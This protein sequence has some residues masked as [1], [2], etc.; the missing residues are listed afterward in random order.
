MSE[1][2]TYNIFIN[3]DR[4]PSVVEPNNGARLT[5]VSRL[6]ELG[7]DPIG[8]MNYVVLPEDA[9]DAYRLGAA[10]AAT[11]FLNAINCEDNQGVDS[12]K[13]ANS[14]EAFAAAVKDYASQ[15]VR[16]NVEIIEIAEDRPL[17]FY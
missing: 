10:T 11:H 13:Y 15:V 16:A 12:Q 14:L 17:R 8:F 4:S 3:V 6:N 5:V 1:L 7:K 2:R 9:E